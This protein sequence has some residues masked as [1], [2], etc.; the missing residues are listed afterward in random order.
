MLKSWCLQ[1]ILILPAK[2]LVNNKIQGNMLI[3]SQISITLC[4]ELHIMQFQNTYIA[5]SLRYSDSAI[6]CASFV[7]KITWIIIKIKF[8][9][10]FCSN[11]INSHANEWISQFSHNYHT[12]ESH[13]NVSNNSHTKSIIT[14]KIVLYRSKRF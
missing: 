12:N 10:R 8:S 2:F 13:T 4:C 7:H 9:Q 3:Y 11:H 1:N 5:D 14:I 6:D